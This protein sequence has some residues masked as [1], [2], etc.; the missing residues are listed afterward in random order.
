MEELEGESEGMLLIDREVQ[1]KLVEVLGHTPK[2]VIVG[3][4]I[5]IA[6]GV[7]LG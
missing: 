7:I 2:Q 5:G 4:I 3:A 6:V 1:E